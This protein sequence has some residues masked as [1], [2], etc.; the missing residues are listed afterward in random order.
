MNTLEQISSKADVL[1]EVLPWIQEFRNS[2][3]LIKYGGSA[4]EDPERVDNV[5]K[6][7]VLLKSVGV[8]PIIVHG[9]G[10]M[11]N[12]KLEE[13]G[14]KARFVSGLRI[15][16]EAT[17]KVVEDVL[18][19]IINHDLVQR[20]QKLGAHAESISGREVLHVKKQ[21]PIQKGNQLIDLEFVGEVIGCQAQRLKASL[22]KNLIPVISPLGDNGKGNV[23][24]INADVAAAEIAIALNA[25]KLIYLSD[26]N[27]ILSDENDPDSTISSVTPDDILELKERGVIKEGMLPKVDSCLK[28]LNAGVQKIH[29][30]DGNLPHALLLEMFTNEGI[31]TE[32]IKRT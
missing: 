2:I 6:D 32:L 8:N 27:G 24:N 25:R 5:L 17:M 22:E 29:L 4:M 3:L 15:T 19:N 23:F 31:G 13:K 11:I 28:A 30:L 9:G 16:D 21:E 18:N 14:V 1:T 26:V 20:L 12:R 7:V 10:K